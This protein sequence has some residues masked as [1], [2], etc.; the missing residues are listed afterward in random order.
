M[1]LGY[2]IEHVI[3]DC[4]REKA[5]VLNTARGKTTEAKVDIYASSWGSLNTWIE[6]RLAQ[7]K[8][9]IELS[10]TPQLDPVKLYEHSHFI[11]C[12]YFRL[13]F[14]LLGND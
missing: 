4:L 7:H 3:N 2:T 14:F 5:N 13:W 1:S 12:K 6:T 11:G 9:S 10:I 8:V